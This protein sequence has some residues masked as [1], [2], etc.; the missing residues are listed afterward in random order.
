MLPNVEFFFGEDDD[1][2]SFRRLVGKRRELSRFGKFSFLDAGSGMEGAGLAIAKR[3]GSGFVQQQGA[4]VTSGFDVELEAEALWTAAARQ[5]KR[6]A[7]LAWPHAA[8]PPCGQVLSRRDERVL[9]RVAS[10]G[11][12]HRL[13]GSLNGGGAKLVAVSPARRSLEDLLVREVREAAGSGERPS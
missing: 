1:A 3:D 9:V 2:A 5:G 4:D 7:S 11:D 12:L 6:V 10:Q 13:V 8:D